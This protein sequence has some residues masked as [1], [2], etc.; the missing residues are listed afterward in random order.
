MTVPHSTRRPSLVVHV[1]SPL[2]RK[3]REFPAKK[4]SGHKRVHFSITADGVSVPKNDEQASSPSYT[5]TDEDIRS[6]WWSS[7]E[8]EEHSC[9]RRELMHQ[10]QS[11]QP[12][13]G[14]QYCALYRNCARLTISQ[15]ARMK[16]VR[17]LIF[18][19]QQTQDHRAS[20]DNDEDDIRGLESRL[21]RAVAHYRKQHVQHLV[22]MQNEVAS[23]EK[24][25]A[26]SLQSS[27][28]ASIIARL[29][30]QADAIQAREEA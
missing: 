6:I 15:V 23:D 30:A 21:T 10:F 22:G 9:E 19:Q 18:G 16:S 1:S 14:E 24:L 28:S 17:L 25:S 26:Q 29:W 13:F 8:I 4:T 27:R 20:N 12:G 3:H 11:E 7:D 2:V 5:L